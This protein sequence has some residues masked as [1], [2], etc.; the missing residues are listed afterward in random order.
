VDEFEMKFQNV[1]KTIEK[2]GIQITDKCKH[3]IK[4]NEA[5]TS[6]LRVLNQ[7]VLA[8]HDRIAQ[9]TRELT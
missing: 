5:K 7:Q 1:Y 6:E 2:A 9:E 4:L 8:Q 3:E